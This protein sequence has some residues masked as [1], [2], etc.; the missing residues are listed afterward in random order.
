MS[1]TEMERI[2]EVLESMTAD[3]DADCKEPGCPDCAQW[4]PVWD[5]MEQLRDALGK[6]QAYATYTDA[7][8]KHRQFTHAEGCWSWGP[9]HY[10]CAC[11]ELA[12]AKGWAK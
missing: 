4:R 11:R 8:S 10:A 1:K 5:L 9:A 2:L 7:L 12:K 3:L 6:E